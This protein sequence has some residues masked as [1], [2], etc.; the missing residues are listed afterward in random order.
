MTTLT[1]VEYLNN[2]TALADGTFQY[3]ITASVVDPGELPHPN[4]FVYQYTDL[5][6]PTQDIFIR[7]STPYD[8]ENIP[9]GRSTS[10]T[11]GNTFYLTSA[12]VRNYTDLN[13]AIQAKDAV[14]SRVN[15]GVKAWYDYNSTFSGDTTFYHPTADAT[16]EVQLQDAYY[17]A[18]TTRQ[19]AEVA[20]A[21]TE[22]TLTAARTSA[23]SQAVI[24]ANY[25]DLLDRLTLA[26]NSW[27]LYKGA[28]GTTTGSSGFASFSQPYQV[29]MLAMLTAEVANT[30]AMYPVY[31]GYI[32][33]QDSVIQTQ[34]NNEYLIPKVDQYL[35]ESYALLASNLSAAQAQL[36]ITNNAIS[37][38]TIAKKEAE[39]ELASAQ[40]AEDAALAAAVAICPTFVPTST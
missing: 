2:T 20:L 37:T 19:E 10:I 13:T 9:I 30:D 25:K 16:Y 28:T 14:K 31:L 24:V 1:R 40:A 8:L 12:L 29:K 23:A 18:R 39:A 3:T 22:V 34:S 7:V 11:A 33:N 5:V 6:D 35:D 26:R 15:D 21:A 32:H 17:A 4:L 27:A 36:T 38:A